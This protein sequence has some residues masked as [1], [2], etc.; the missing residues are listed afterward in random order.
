ML[1][2]DS[3]DAALPQASPVFQAISSLMKQAEMHREESGSPDLE[4]TELDVAAQEHSSKEEVPLAPHVDS[5]PEP[6]VQIAPLEKAMVS[7]PRKKLLSRLSQNGLLNGEKDRRRQERDLKDYPDIAALANVAKTKDN[8]Y[9]I[10]GSPQ[11]AS[12]EPKELP[13]CSLPLSGYV[14]LVSP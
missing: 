9:K 2:D 8:F 3:H 11:A 14:S 4:K 1:S 7:D 10:M 6:D 12:R 13:E 5:D